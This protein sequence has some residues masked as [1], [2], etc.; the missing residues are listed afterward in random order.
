MSSYE[1]LNVKLATLM[2]MNEKM[3]DDVDITLFKEYL[4]LRLPYA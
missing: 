2:T 1:N 4:I 3:R